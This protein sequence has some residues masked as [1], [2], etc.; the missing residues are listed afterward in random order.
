M[1]HW[2]C[3]WGVWRCLIP[4]HQIL[5]LPPKQNNPKDSYAE[6]LAR[7]HVKVLG[8]PN[9]DDNELLKQFVDPPNASVLKLETTQI[10]VT[11][12]SQ[13][14]QWE[15]GSS[16]NNP[17]TE[18][19]ILLPKEETS[20]PIPAKE[21]RVAK[22][23]AT[24]ILDVPKKEVE[25]PKKQKP[26]PVFPTKIVAPRAHPFSKETHVRVKIIV[27]DIDLNIGHVGTPGSESV[28]W[29]Q[30]DAIKQYLTLQ[31]FERR[32]AAMEGAVYRTVQHDA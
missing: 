13:K 29:M 31:D 15:A 2:Q 9:H 18:T 17:M 10:L 23:I 1:V 5:I 16:N 25:K 27:Q 30:R 6:R 7:E 12:L 22:T 21:M 19:P 20:A 4:L 24:P 28:T 26:T 3:Q 8:T 32:R 14:Q 11:K